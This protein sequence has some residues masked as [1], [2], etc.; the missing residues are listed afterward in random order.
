MREENAMLVS[1]PVNFISLALFAIAVWSMGIEALSTDLALRSSRWLQI[2]RRERAPM[3]ILALGRIPQIEMTQLAT[4]PPGTLIADIERYTE[5]HQQQW[6]ESI[7]II[8]MIPH[9]PATNLA[10]TRSFQRCREV[11]S[12]SR[13]G[14]GK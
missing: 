5:L 14:P 4:T 9:I 8:V 2:T 12:M 7:D 10:E 11:A 3:K 1:T 13:E 6:G